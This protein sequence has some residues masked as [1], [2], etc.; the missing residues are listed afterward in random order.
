MYAKLD[1]YDYEIITD[2]ETGIR[3]IHIALDSSNDVLASDITSYILQHEGLIY[4][5]GDRFELF[6]SSVE[7]C[8]DLG[9]FLILCT[10]KLED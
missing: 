6:K 7:R 9:V 5:D 1:E 10:R 3:Y 8:G 2:E 4:L